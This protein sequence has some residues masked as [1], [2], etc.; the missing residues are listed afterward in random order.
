MIHGDDYDDINK[1]NVATGQ[2]N[3]GCVSPPPSILFLARCNHGSVRMKQRASVV[4]F[5]LRKGKLNLISTI[6]QKK[7]KT[8]KTSYLERLHRVVCSFNV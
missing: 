3:A 4:F 6:R 2:R 5:F 1:Q 8:S 7:I